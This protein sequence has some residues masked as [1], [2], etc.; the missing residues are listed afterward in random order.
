LS[1]QQPFTLI[2]EGMMQ[3]KGWAPNHVTIAGASYIAAVVVALL[4]SLPYWRM[5]GV[6]K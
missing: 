3:G 6:I 2:A 4:I 5:I 1:Y